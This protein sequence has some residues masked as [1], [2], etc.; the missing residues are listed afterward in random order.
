MSIERYKG[1]G[2]SNRG[3]NFP[4]LANP[5]LTKAVNIAIH[6]GR[7]LLIK[8]PP[9]CGKTKLAYA[10]AHEIDVPI[11][12]W[13]VKSTSRAAD[14]LYTI[15]M[16]RRLQD[17]HL[18]K[19]RAQR[20]TPYISF[21]AL[22]TALK[23]GKEC[24]VLIDEIDKADIDFPNDLLREL[25]ERRFTIEEIDQSK[26]TAEEKEQGFRRTYPAPEVDARPPIVVVT[27]N[28][29]KELPQAFLRRCVFHSIAFPDAGRLEEIVAV[30]LPDLT[31]AQGL[32]R[33][34]IEV[35]EQ[36]RKIDGVRKKPE[37]SELIDWIRVLHHWGA[38][39]DELSEAPPVGDLPHW[40]VLFKHE[41]D[42][43]AV[44][45]AATGS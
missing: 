4:Y 2:A 25:D 22:G 26:L 15:D 10:I 5:D 7:P 24:V 31:L 11:Y 17:S 13:Y 3:D 30:N 18:D 42:L 44:Q 29:E 19:E 12:P 23:G 6:L 28:D 8:G 35:L 45:S 16:V 14:G 37:T 34:A 20:V 21:G 27:S 38:D 43:Q 32:V 9:G 41:R 1:T 36:F 40:E 39:L 33:R